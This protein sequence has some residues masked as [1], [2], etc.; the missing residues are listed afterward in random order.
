MTPLEQANALLKA[1]DAEGLK[2]LR[3][4]AETLP[5]YDWQWTTL[6]SDNGPYQ[7]HE[8][9][10]EGLAKMVRHSE[11]LGLHAITWNDEDVD[12]KSSTVCITGNGPTSP[13][14]AQ[15]IAAVKP[16]NMLFILSKLDES[17]SALLEKHKALEAAEARLSRLSTLLDEAEAALGPFAKVSE[18]AK[19]KDDA[20]WCGQDGAVILYADLRRAFSLAAKIAKEKSE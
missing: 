1:A 12:G 5:P 19:G 11:S 17:A 9:M 14:H 2:K 6:T 13:L 20:C 15:Y 10:I 7:S 8:D 16:S 3:D 18:K 4:L